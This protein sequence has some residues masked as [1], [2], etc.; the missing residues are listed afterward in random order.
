MGLIDKS[1]RLRDVGKRGD[2]LSQHCCCSFQSMATQV[3]AGRALEK[4]SEH[5]GKMDRMNPQH[6]TRLW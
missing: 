5:S 2:A 3:F 1:R 4:A 6:P